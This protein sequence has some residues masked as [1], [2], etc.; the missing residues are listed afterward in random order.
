MTE[1]LSPFSLSPFDWMLFVSCALLIGM[2]K[3]GV[4][5]VSMFVVPT[6]AL[7]FGGKQSTG[8]LLPIL[9]LADVFAV[10]YYHR[11]AEWFH[12][13]RAL[14]WALAGLFFALWIG[15]MV[16]DEQFKRII[17]ITVFASVALMIWKDYYYKKEFTPDKWWFAAI[18]GVV[19]GFATMIGNVAGPIF[20]I[21]LLA[22]HLNKKNFIGTN[23]WF[24]FIINL[25]KFPLQAIV[26][27]NISLNTLA[28]DLLVLPAIAIGAWLGIMIVKR[29]PEKTYKWFIITI[30]IVSA[31]LILI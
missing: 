31:F 8:V 12:L 2:S 24:F 25:S 23:A 30:T 3:T 13:L 16:N 10:I 15:N 21:Y 29:I 14:P 26:W 18:L 17:A 20:A 28:I 27:K 4:P 19:G 7:I 1:F 22:L 9:I 6:L 11:F 5:G